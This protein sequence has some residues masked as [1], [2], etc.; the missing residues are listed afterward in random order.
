MPKMLLFG[1]VIGI[2]FLIYII[3]KFFSLPGVKVEVTSPPEQPK[4][5]MMPLLIAVAVL[6]VGYFFYSHP[7][8][9]EKVDL[10]IL[11][12]D[13]QRSPDKGGAVDYYY[14]TDPANNRYIIGNL[15]AK[16][17]AQL[18]RVLDSDQEYGRLDEA[19]LR[20]V[21]GNDRQVVEAYYRFLKCSNLMRSSN[22]VVYPAER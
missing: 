20:R 8:V 5:I 1:G 21:A 19:A 7:S 9:L 12:L 3:D 16:Q 2:F 6:G 15:Q 18:D 17:L 22:H 13:I 4:S 11:D 14:D 10:T